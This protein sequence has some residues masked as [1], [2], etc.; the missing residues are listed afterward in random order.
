MEKVLE[1]PQV[2]CDHCIH[3]I[4]SAVNDIEGVSRVA[5]DLEAKNVTV[6]FDE[7]KVALA[8]IIETIEDQG[9]DVGTGPKL[10]DLGKPKH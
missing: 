8:K 5:V 10:I 9:Y 3:S 7:D 4:E 1:V 6:A 2:H